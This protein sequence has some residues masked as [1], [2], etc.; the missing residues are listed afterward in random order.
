MANKE[1]RVEGL[2]QNFHCCLDIDYELSD[3]TGECEGFC[4]R[5]T[6][7]NLRVLSV[8]FASIVKTICHDVSPVVRYCVDRILMAYKLYESDLWRIETVGGYYGEEIGDVTLSLDVVRLCD[9]AIAKVMAMKDDNERF[10]FVLELEYGYLLDILKG[11]NFVLKDVRKS[12]LVFGQVDHY[13]KLEK[14]VIESYRHYKLPRGVCVA[15][16]GGKYRVIDGYHRCAAVDGNRKC[17]VF[18]AE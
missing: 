14:R 8:D 13:R 2:L 4:R 17:S 6:L 9:E 16:D 15:I 1:P 7:E 12:D 18:I 11:K 5:T 10:V 3:C